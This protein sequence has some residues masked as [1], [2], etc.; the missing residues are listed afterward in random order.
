MEVQIRKETP[1]DYFETEAMTRRAFFNKFI[2]GCNEHLL[3]HNLRTHPSYLPEYSRIAVA[4]GHVVGTIMYFMARIETGER[5]IP[6]PTFG[7]LCVD[8]RY[9]NHGIGS[10]LLQHTLP[11]LKAAGYPGV[12]IVGEPDFYPKHGF[13]R[14]GTLGLT[15]AEGNVYD[16]FMALEF[17]P[18]ALRIPGGRFVEPED[19]MELPEETLT[20]LDAQF[21][22]LMKAHRPVQWTYE[23]AEDEKNGYHLEYAVKDPAA[24]KAL[25]ADYLMELAQDDPALADADPAE[26]VAEIR[27]SVTDAAYLIKVDGKNAG[28]VV[29]SV[30]EEPLDEKYAQSYLQEIYVA[31]AYRRRGIAGDIF[32]RFIRNQEHD[33]GLCM[34]EDSPA[35]RLWKKLLTQAGYA[36]DLFNEDDVRV[37]CQ[38]HIPKK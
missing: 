17:I 35:G 2:P 25:F 8:H 15:D 33:T 5:T 31:P 1:A 38:V 16:P 13:I 24:F 22:F 3:V 29:T 6:V 9:K 19:L 34:V 12:I 37:F 11:L 30:P 32:L 18:D 7:P 20:A 28:L 26:F 10:L 36:Y 4:D 21:P 14:A 23:N 27:E